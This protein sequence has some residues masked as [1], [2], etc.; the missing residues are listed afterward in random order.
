MPVVL[1]SQERVKKWLDCDVPFESCIPLL[2]PYKENCLSW[3]KVSE[4]VGSTRNQKVQCLEP[5]EDVMKRKRDNGIARFFTSASAKSK[6][7]QSTRKDA[8]Q[9]SSELGMP[10]SSPPSALHLL[11]SEADAKKDLK[12]PSKKRKKGHVMSSQVESS[13][14]KSP[15]KHRR[16]EDFFKPKD[17]KQNDMKK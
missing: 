17:K 3:Y 14:Q 15:G 9:K 12:I 4:Y 7:E 16:I 10:T 6:I 5:L 13:P 8:S 11:T 2:S 1:A